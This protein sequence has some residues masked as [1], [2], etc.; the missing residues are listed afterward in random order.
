MGGSALS[1]RAKECYEAASAADSRSEAQATF[2]GEIDPIPENLTQLLRQLYLHGSTIVSMRISL[3]ISST[4][5]KAN[6]RQ[7][8]DWR[9]RLLFWQEWY[10]VPESFNQLLPH[11]PKDVGLRNSDVLSTVSTLSRPSP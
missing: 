11:Y 9:R 5:Y 3:D 8:Q 1:S 2:T 6:R 10:D 7:M 4:Y